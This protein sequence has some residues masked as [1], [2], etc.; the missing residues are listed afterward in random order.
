MTF[1]PEARHERLGPLECTVVN[2]GA[3]PSIAVL[4]CHGYGAPGHDL[5]GIAVEWIKLLGEDAGAF[6]F[7]FPA[8][9]GTLEE[10]GMPE[11]RAWWPINMARLAQQVQTQRFEELHEHEPPGLTEARS[12]LAAT[13]QATLEGLDGQESPFVLGGFSQGAMLTMDLTLRGLPRPPRMLLQFSGTLIC[14]SAWQAALEKRAERPEFPMTV[15]QSHGTLDSILPFSSAQSLRDL[16]RDAGIDVT[17]HSF[18]G[19]HTID[20]DSIVTTAQ[21]LQRLSRS[22]ADR[23]S[24]DRQS[25]GDR[26]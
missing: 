12:A 14:R 4:L 11:G 19:P 6:R 3:D 8:A 5:V 13:V 10:L 21:M 15:F 24:A 2:G 18:D 17:F 22:L 20:V 26:Q 23:Q 1:T 7:V 16:L 9:A 25:G